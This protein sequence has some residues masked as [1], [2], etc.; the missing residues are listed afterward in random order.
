MAAPSVAQAHRGDVG[1]EEQNE[2]PPAA[3]SS[4]ATCI[5]GGVSMATLGV[6]GT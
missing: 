4:P 2:D 3:A 5:Q 6:V 1:W